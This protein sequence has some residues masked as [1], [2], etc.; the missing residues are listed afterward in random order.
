M[1]SAERLEDCWC[2]VRFAAR[3]EAEVGNL[4]ASLAL[5]RIGKDINFI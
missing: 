3:I 4:S 1:T 5:F 2:R